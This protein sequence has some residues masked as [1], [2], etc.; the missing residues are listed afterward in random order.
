M[1][2]DMYLAPEYTQL[3]IE[4]NKLKNNVAEKIAERDWLSFYAFPEIKHNYNLKLGVNEAKLFIARVNL[5][6]LKRKI[7]IYK[8]IIKYDNEI[9]E[10]KIDNLIDKEFKNELHE[11]ALM[12]EDIKLAI[13]YTHKE[14]IS[15][16]SFNRLNY[17]YKNLILKLCPLLNL[18]NT[19]LENELYDILEVAYKNFDLNKMFGLVVICE[20]N[21]INKDLEI[22]DFD[23]LIKLKNIYEKL[24]EENKRIILNIRTSEIFSNK[25]LLDNEI[26][27]RRKKD[28]LNK[29]IE[30][31]SKEYLKLLKEFDK[32]KKKK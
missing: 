11:Y 21:N 18:K 29:N 10:Q 4:V 13:E 9:S 7:A 24:L 14:Q 22:D 8:E 6:K 19:R 15:E 17:L 5:D 20:K 30:E 32:I 28:D 26:L 23:N 27:L 2:F 25:N 3:I 31:I 1:S 12:Q 16:E